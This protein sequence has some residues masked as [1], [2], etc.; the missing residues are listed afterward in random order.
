MAQYVV[1]ENL[2]GQTLKDIRN[3]KGL[4]F[5]PDI[6]AGFGGVNENTPLTAGTVFNL[7]NDP[8]SAE[9][10][11]GSQIFTPQAQYQSAQ[12]TAKIQALE[13]KQQAEEQGFL[14]A[15]NERIAGQETLPAAYERISQEKKLPEYQET[16]FNAAENL[17]QTINEIRDI[18]P[19]QQT[20]S[21]QVGISAPRLQQR[22]SALRTAKQPELET[23]T[24]AAESAF[25]QQQF[26]GEQVGQEL[27]YLIA[28]QEKDLK[29]FY[30]AQMPLLQERLARE[31]TNYSEE[32]QRE[33]DLIL[34]NIRQSG[35]ANQRALDRANELAIAELGYQSELDKIRISTDEAI[36]EYEEKLALKGNEPGGIPSLE[37][38]EETMNA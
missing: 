1:G 32:K 2:A 34:E 38:L 19:R 9:V 22:I 36:R 21:K 5:R 16:S 11:Y 35:T 20:F 25:A 33:L 3:K 12:N 13:Q 27:G 10:I 6:L 4:A 30:E 8:G 29:P 26:T 7:P 14:S 28:Q 15:L 31:Q 17:R 37:E 23:A 18:A 24:R